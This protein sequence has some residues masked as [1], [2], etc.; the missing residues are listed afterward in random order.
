MARWRLRTGT[1]DVTVVAEDQ[2]TA[3]DTL[4][5]NPTEDFGLI[6]LGTPDE[7]DPVAVKTEALMRRWDRASDAQAFHDAAVLQGLVPE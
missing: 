4:R 5:D 3:W 6:V 1:I 7:G 2:W